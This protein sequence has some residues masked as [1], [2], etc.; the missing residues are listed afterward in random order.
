ML[1]LKD[2]SLLRQQCYL[3][4][5]W[6]DADSGATIEVTNPATGEYLASV[7][8]MGSAEA[9]RAVAAAQKAFGPWKKKTAK[10]RA[11]ILRRW[12]PTA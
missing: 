9:E 4:G 6:Q 1:N 2:P 5:Q 3:D 12:L 8:K 11:L 7:P 10:E